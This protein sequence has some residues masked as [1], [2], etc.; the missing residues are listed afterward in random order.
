VDKVSDA[1]PEYIEKEC[2]GCGVG[3]GEPCLNPDGTVAIMLHRERFK[4]P[5]E[6]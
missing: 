6:K 4:N 3:P 2:P 5:E 1:E